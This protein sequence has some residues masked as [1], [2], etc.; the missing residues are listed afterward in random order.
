LND[1]YRAHRA[2]GFGMAAPRIQVVPPGFFAGWMSARGR[3]GG[4]NKVPRVINDR[5][6][7][8]DLRGFIGR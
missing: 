6:L 4:Q 7:F 8:A 2:E 3:L 1:D 5:Q